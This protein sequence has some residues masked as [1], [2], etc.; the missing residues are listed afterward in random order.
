MPQVPCHQPAQ[1]NT[2]FE[3]QSLFFLG[4]HAPPVGAD[5]TDCDSHSRRHPDTPDWA[6][7]YRA[8][9]PGPKVK[10]VSPMPLFSSLLLASAC[11]QFGVNS[12]LA[13]LHKCPLG[14]RPCLTLGFPS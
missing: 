3:P 13:L 7:G 8:C 6:A 12:L 14:I 10:S 1:P 2:S 4:L 11:A 9:L 5:R